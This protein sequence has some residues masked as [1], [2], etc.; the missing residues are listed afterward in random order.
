MDDGDG[1]GDDDDASANLTVN[2]SASGSVLDLLKG[3][4]VKTAYV[5]V[6]HCFLKKSEKWCFS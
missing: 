4:F 2:V 1:G 3:K 5:N 6:H